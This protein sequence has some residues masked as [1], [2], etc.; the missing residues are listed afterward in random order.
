MGWYTTINAKNWIIFHVG[1]DPTDL[2]Y[3]GQL[4]LIIPHLHNVIFP[5][6]RRHIFS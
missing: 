6:Q 5:N 4:F 1:N 2:P 3:A